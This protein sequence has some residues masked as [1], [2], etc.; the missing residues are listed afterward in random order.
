MSESKVELFDVSTQTTL[1]VIP[2]FDYGSITVEHKS[3]IIEVVGL[4]KSM[5]QHDIAKMVNT[6]F[7]IQEPNRYDLT[8][9]PF[10]QACTATNIYCAVQ[11]HIQSGTDLDAMHY[12]LVTMSEDIRKFEKLYEFIKNN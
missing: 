12:P 1:E 5:G 9:S 6:R 2:N 11:G 8:Q 7:K 3:A 10:V 4:L